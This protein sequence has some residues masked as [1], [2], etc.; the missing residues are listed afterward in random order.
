[1]QMFYVIYYVYQKIW[2]IY[3]FSYSNL[4]NIYVIICKV[5]YRH[6][7]NYNE[8]TTATL[9]RLTKLYYINL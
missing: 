1:M 2:K 6:L 8:S 3:G 9:L 7:L 5:R 4:C